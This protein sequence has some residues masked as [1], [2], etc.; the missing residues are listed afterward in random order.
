M[1]IQT[2][3]IK[4]KRRG[5]GFSNRAF[6]REITNELKFFG[7]DV[8]REFDGVVSDWT[9][10]NRPK[11][12]VETRTKSDEITVIVRPFK[13]RKASRIFKWV[14]EG[15]RPHVIRPKPGNKTGRLFFR[16]GYQPKTLP[17]AKAHAGPGIATGPLVIAKSVRHPGTKPR[18]FT[19]TIMKKSRPVF[20][21][22][23]ENA[24]KRAVRKLK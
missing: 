6:K 1:V 8:K 10:K 13:R 20:R 11:F 12:V 16:T 2:R 19:Q 3:R 21:R 7:K 15:T 4:S 14:D 5:A 24:F 9:A 23:M 17:V 22:R 18:L